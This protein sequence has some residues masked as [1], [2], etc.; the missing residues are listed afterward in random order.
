[1]NYLCNLLFFTITSVEISKRLVTELNMYLLIE[2]KFIKKLK[3]L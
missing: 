2:I 3:W 1:M